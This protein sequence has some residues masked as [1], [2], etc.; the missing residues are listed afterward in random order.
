MVA[1]E[2]CDINSG[3][4]IFENILSIRVLEWLVIKGTSREKLYHEQGFESFE[5]RK[6]HWKLFLAFVNI[7]ILNTLKKYFWQKFLGHFIIRPNNFERLHILDKFRT[8]QF[9]AE[10][11]V[12]KKQKTDVVSASFV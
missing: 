6:P 12:L 10:C 7:S 9:S 1:T 2:L 3:S 5:I 8:F 4:V 11:S